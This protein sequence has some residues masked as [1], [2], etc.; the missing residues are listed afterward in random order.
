M[1]FREF[2]KENQSCLKAEPIDIGPKVLSTQPSKRKQIYKKYIVQ[3]NSFQPVGEVVTEKT[4]PAGVFRIQR[5]MSGVFFEV[6]DINTDDI[7]RFEDSRYTKILQE[8]DNFWTLKDDFKKYGFT[9]K[10]GVLLY[11]QPGSGKSALLKLAMEDMVSKG[12]IV[13]ITREAHDL[14]EA[15]KVVREV[16]PERK[17]LV[18][19]EDIDEIVK[20]GEHAILELF[21]GDAQTN[22]VLFLGTTNYIDRLPPRI[23]RASRFDRKIEIGNPP[24]TGRYAYLKAKLKEHQDEK[25]IME[26]AEKTKDFT[27]AQ[28]REFIVSAFCLKQN[29]DEVIKRL[30]SNLESH[31]KESTIYLSEKTML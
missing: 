20:Y 23:L 15:L 14:V 9:H 21:D 19:M 12:N 1:S 11:G 6:H 13:F 7:L 27:F 25:R 2:I 18:I 8:I 24:T 17:I 31:L 4:I 10:R 5:N 28:L 3:G 30:R 29:E 16:E 22:N 26:L